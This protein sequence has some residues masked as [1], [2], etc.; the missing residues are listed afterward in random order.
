MASSFFDMFLGGKQESI[1]QKAQLSVKDILTVAN[2]GDILLFRGWSPTSSFIQIFTASTWSHI[3]LIIKLPNY[4]GGQPMVLEAIHSDDDHVDSKFKP[5][6]DI[7]T[8][9]A[10][11]GV[12]LVDLYEYLKSIVQE[13]KVM[14]HNDHVR[15]IEITY[16]CLVLHSAMK[17]LYSTFL[18]HLNTVAADFIEEN[19]GKPYEQNFFEIILARF[20]LGDTSGYLTP[21]SLFC[22][23]LV[24][25]FLLKA[26]LVKLKYV[27]PNSL[28]P[29]DFSST[30]RITLRYPIEKLPIFVGQIKDPEFVVW[31]SEE[32]VIDTISKIEIP[33]KKK[34]KGDFIIIHEG[35][36]RQT[37]RAVG[38]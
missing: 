9:E 3:A 23:E 12:R 29:D 6:L 32:Y 35:Q 7:K 31:Y 33:R 24:G 37:R 21:D 22:S 19:R 5:L 28:L 34:K 36:P 14:A 30:S 8:K 27:T 2:T 38:K 4:N 26:G 10:H 13:N 18:L 11:C 17:H 25:Y 16:R 20:Q 1:T 15:R